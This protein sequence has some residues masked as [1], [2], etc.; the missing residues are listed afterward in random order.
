MTWECKTRVTDVL[1]Y[2]HIF[3]DSAPFTLRTVLFW[4]INYTATFPNTLVDTDDFVSRVQR[5]SRKIH[6]CPVVLTRCRG[7]YHLL[8]SSLLSPGDSQATTGKGCLDS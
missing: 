6:F 3:T 5:K 4:K 7:L 2:A 1:V 8:P